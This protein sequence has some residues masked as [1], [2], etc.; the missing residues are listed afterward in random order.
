MN[1]IVYVKLLL[2]VGIVLKYFLTF[3]VSLSDVFVSIK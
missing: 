1:L 3:V 2:P